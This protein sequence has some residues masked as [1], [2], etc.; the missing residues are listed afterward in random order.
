MITDIVQNP[1]DI[2]KSS[3]KRPWT[4]VF[5]LPLR[6]EMSSSVWGKRKAMGS[7]M[8][9]AC[10]AAVHRVHMVAETVAE[11]RDQAGVA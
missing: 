7:Q 4:R 11:M 6:R 5:P 2:A 1:N 3:Y 10:G 8:P 9:V